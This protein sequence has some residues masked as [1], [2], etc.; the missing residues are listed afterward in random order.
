MIAGVATPVAWNP[1]E[2]DGPDLQ[3]AAV[4][5]A[6]CDIFFAADGY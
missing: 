6:Y 1:I 2:S 3:H 4:A 5:M